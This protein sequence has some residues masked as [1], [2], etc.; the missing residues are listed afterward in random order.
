MNHKAHET[1][2]WNAGETMATKCANSRN[3]TGNSRS[4]YITSG[5][6]I[7]THENGISRILNSLSQN[8]WITSKICEQVNRDQ[9]IAP[10]RKMKEKEKKQ[11]T[12]VES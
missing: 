10:K 2:W 5:A 4:I 8:Q 9:D 6:N 7:H 11:I 3:K 1:R 12:E